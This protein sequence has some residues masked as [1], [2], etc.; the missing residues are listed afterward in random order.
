M[1]RTLLII[2]S[3]LVICWLPSSSAQVTVNSYVDKTVLG[4]AETLA[5]T[6]EVSGDLQ[7]LGTIQAP[8]ATGMTLAS[9]TPVLRSQ[10]T[11]NTGADQLTL[12]WL[13][14][15]QRI[16]DAQ[17]FSARI[18]IGNRT[19]TTNPIEIEIV[20]Q[21]QRGAAR[22]SR[23]PQGQTVTPEPADVL[24]D[25]DLFIRGVPTTRNAV[26][27]EQILVDY[28]LYYKPGFRPRDSEISGSLN[29]E[30][31]WR[32][33]LDIPHQARVPRR[34]T[35]N[36]ED[37]FAATLLRIAL[38][39]TRSGPLELSEMQIRTQLVRPRQSSGP[40]DSFFS[41]F[42][43]RLVTEELTA[44]AVRFSISDLPE[45]APQSFA[46]S[47]GRFGM[48]AF[49]DTDDVDAGNPV[50]LTIELQGQGNIATL[51][52]PTLDLPASFEVI[53]PS[54][55]RRIDLS[56]GPIS[57]SKTFTYSLIPQRS[58]SFELPSIEWSYFD[59]DTGAFETLR[60][61]TFNLEIG[62]S[63]AAAELAAERIPN[64]P[65]VPVGMLTATSW[66]Q[67]SS[68]SRIPGLVIVGGFG[69]PLLALLA[70]FGI[71]KVRT[72]EPDNSPEALATRAHPLAKKHLKE[73][74]AALGSLEFYHTIEHALRKFVSDR[75]HISGMGTSRSELHRVLEKACVPVD[76]IDSLDRLLASC[77]SAQFAPDTSIDRSAQERI[78]Q[79]AGQ[80][81]GRIDESTKHPEA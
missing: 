49:T 16:G 44:D 18:P 57:G 46:G 64:D 54:E 73:A 14:R 7:N 65:T 81:I 59:P 5:Y 50:E 63:V 8:D 17:I 70:L 3:G 61:S 33:T 43:N 56:R 10:M 6:L 69:L 42:S 30:G 35:I 48:A 78:L 62:G 51:S 68:D 22:Q 29:A 27:G 20:P 12:R 1:S 67:T 32:E 19:L 47:V 77:E 55:D 34:V 76:A 45:N 79:Q 40:F 52:P 41:P 11:T 25:G 72:R 26:V 39:P 31:F 53:G 15:P 71:Q 80:T 75:L 28:I 66:V 38:F 2:L 9:G 4:D 37:Y 23:I 36:G 58:G 13:Y 21:S 74:R 60:S 24:A